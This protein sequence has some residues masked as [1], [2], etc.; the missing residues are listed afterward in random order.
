LTN[1]HY[2]YSIIKLE[3]GLF[4]I[5]NAKLGSSLQVWSEDGECIQT[6]DT[7][8]MAY[9][10]TRLRDGSLVTIDGKRLEIRRL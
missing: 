5:A 8:G 3:A 7:G 10:M 4:A 2:V 9:A 1:G 6:I